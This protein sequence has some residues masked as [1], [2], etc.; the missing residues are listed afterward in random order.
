VEIQ[1]ITIWKSWAGFEPAISA[2]PRQCSS[3]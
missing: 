1:L 3:Y 2:I